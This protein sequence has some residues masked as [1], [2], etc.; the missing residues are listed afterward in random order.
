MIVIIGAMRQKT[1]RLQSNAGL[2]ERDESRKIS[3]LWFVRRMR[4]VTPRRKH[5][6]PTKIESG[7]TFG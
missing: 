1:R 4:F 2:A 6:F 3:R 5:F 7:F